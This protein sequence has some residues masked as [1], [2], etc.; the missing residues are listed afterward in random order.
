MIKISSVIITYNEE[1]DLPRCIEC[2]KRVAD[3]IIIVDSYSTDTIS[4]YKPYLP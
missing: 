3:E 4:S 2:L 1:A